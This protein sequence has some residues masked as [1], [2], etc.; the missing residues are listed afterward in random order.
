MSATI[1]NPFQDAAR[2]ADSL[3]RLESCFCEVGVLGKDL[4]ILENLCHLSTVRN[5][6]LCVTSM[7]YPSSC[8]GR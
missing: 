7:F 1:L 3:N 4:K 8:V 6:A 5:L 2:R